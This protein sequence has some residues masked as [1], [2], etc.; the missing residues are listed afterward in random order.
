MQ[1]LRERTAA[2][3]TATEELPLMR[4]LLANDASISDY[5]RYLQALHGVYLTVEPA[6]YAAVSPP[7]LSRLGIRP[8]LPALQRDLN[9]LGVRVALPTSGW[10]RRLREAVTGEPC[11]LGG[12]YV[13][14]GAT[15]GGQQIARRLRQHWADQPGL[16]YSFLEHR[17]DN[18]GHDWKRF[19]K[20][21]I[22]W[23]E[24]KAARRSVAEGAS[25]ADVDTGR[26]AAVIDGALTVFETMHRALADTKTRA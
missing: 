11:A 6:L 21:L 8:K 2:I 7:L 17:A 19:R 20:T 26:D 4:N 13:L 14:E 24:T 9:R 3:H 12:L 16:P 10:P 22:E 23:A 5:R 25:D 18:P 1:R 15:L